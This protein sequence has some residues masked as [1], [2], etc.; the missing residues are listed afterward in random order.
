MKRL[1]YHSLD[2][3]VDVLEPEK[4]HGRVICLS[5]GTF[6]GYLGQWLYIFEYSTIDK[7]YSLTPNSTTGARTILRS[8]FPEETTFMFESPSIDK[9]YRI[10]E[11]INVKLHAIGVVQNYNALEGVLL[12]KLRDKVKSIERI[13][14]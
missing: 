8:S 10:Y 11:P 2:K 6:L 3:R 5:E 14:L 7:Y 9:E 4:Y 13:H 12:T 1:L